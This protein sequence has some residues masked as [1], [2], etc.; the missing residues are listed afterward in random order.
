MDREVLV[1][2]NKAMAEA[3]HQQP[4]RHVVRHA[5][6]KALAYLP[7]RR[8]RGTFNR[9]LLIRPDHLG[10]MLLTTPAI[11]A[12]KQSH[13]HLELHA[14][15]GPWS[16]QVAAAFPQ[17]DTVLTL[18]FPG[19][20]RA[21]KD[22]L[23]SPYTLAF[24]TARKLRRVG[25]DAAIIFRP[26][27][28]WGA[29]VAHQAGIPR[30]IGY[31]LPDVDPFLADK[32]PYQ[33]D[34]VVRQ[35]MRLVEPFTGLIDDQD[36]VYQYPVDAADTAYIR[37]YLQ[38][39]GLE[40]DESY[41]CIHAG[42]GTWVKRWEDSHWASVADTLAQQL[43]ARAIFTGGDHE[44]SLALGIAEQMQQT[45]LV[46]AGETQ[47]S[48]LAALFAGARI[49]LGPDSGPLHLASAVGTPTVSLYGPARL[50]EFA[51]WGSP[52]QH[53]TLTSDIGC[54]GCGVL[55]WGTDAA[56]YHP[57]VREISVGRVLTAARRAL[58]PG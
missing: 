11:R 20:S 27:H 56:E 36:I 51:P 44:R 14:L 29:M 7:V 21:P 9:V 55:D 19:F 16:S 3:F 10:D 46:I 43:N 17:I 24:E 4:F 47:V 57:C 34:H 2:R 37:A 45:P 41:F 58:N 25:Y 54:L 18:P 1:L 12:L 50:S 22:S 35:N 13:P 49:V 26:D 33:L 32:I 15:V 39:A 48:Q 38:D 40:P 42:A 8:L 28:W 30:V 6:L 23:R 53:I 52:H 5:M 31:A